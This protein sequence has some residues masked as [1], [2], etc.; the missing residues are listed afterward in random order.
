MKN[1]LQCSTYNLKCV[2]LGFMFV[3]A[4]MMYGCAFQYDNVVAAYQDCRQDLFGGQDDM[5]TVSNVQANSNGKWTFDV[6]FQNN[7]PRNVESAVQPQIA[8]Y[9]VVQIVD[10]V[11]SANPAE[12][13]GPQNFVRYAEEE[14]RSG[15]Q[16]GRRNNAVRPHDIVHVAGMSGNVL[17]EHERFCRS[18]GADE[19]GDSGTVQ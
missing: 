18:S 11:V 9:R 12:N 16:G 2:N 17:Y 15:R 3:V 10:N 14:R 13:T 19:S 1:L 7:A 5:F 6:Q 4:M 8:K